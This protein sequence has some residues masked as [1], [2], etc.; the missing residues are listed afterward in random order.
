MYKQ[1]RYE[2]VKVTEMQQ[3]STES[4]NETHC[5]PTVVNIDQKTTKSKTV[6]NSVQ[7]MHS[8]KNLVLE[9]RYIEKPDPEPPVKN[10][11][12]SLFASNKWKLTQKSMQLAVLKK[13]V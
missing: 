13:I 6:A 8:K 10:V 7:D 4:T 5:R 12:R 9:D 3:Q 1:H 2:P 11:N